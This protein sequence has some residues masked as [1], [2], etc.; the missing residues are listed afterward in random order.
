MPSTTSFD[1]CAVPPAR[2]VAPHRRPWLGIAINPDRD[3]MAKS[4]ARKGRKPAS[5]PVRSARR[6]ATPSRS[7][8]SAKPPL[9]KTGKKPKTSKP[10]ANTPS[11]KTA[12]RSQRWVHAFGGGKSAL[13]AD[14]RNLLGGKGAGL[15]EMASLGLP[16]PPGFTITTEV[17]SYYYA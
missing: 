3:H 6:P 17:C 5:K 2:R 11:G 8:L 4:A 7:V 9:L 16:V 12:S 10:A 14:A 15:A 13:R 1:D